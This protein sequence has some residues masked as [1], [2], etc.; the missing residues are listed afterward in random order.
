MLLVWVKDMVF[1]KRLWSRLF[2]CK[3]NNAYISDADR[4]L[5]EFD[6]QNPKHS[7]SQRCEVEKHRNIFYRGKKGRINW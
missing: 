6:H 7:E 3:I 1:L 5:Q 4:F 2:H